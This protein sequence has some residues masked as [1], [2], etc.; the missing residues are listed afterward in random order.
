MSCGPLVQVRSKLLWRLV[1]I[2]MVKRKKCFLWLIDWNSVS[3]PP[4]LLISFIIED[5]LVKVPKNPNKSLFKC[6]QRWRGCP[7][8]RFTCHP[9]HQALQTSMFGT[10]KPR[11][12]WH[13]A[14]L[15]CL[16]TLGQRIAWT[17]ERGCLGMLGF[18]WLGLGAFL[19]FFGRFGSAI[20]AHKLCAQQMRSEASLNYY[21]FE[22]GMDVY[23]TLLACY[24]VIHIFSI[25]ILISNGSTYVYP[26]MHMY[27][28]VDC[29]SIIYICI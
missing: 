20:R 3:S 7:C 6:H 16:P 22:I 15:Q 17:L 23:D 25:P 27:T 5:Y 9:C 11:Y 19:M 1:K 18:L 29:Q 28:F 24:L 21:G 8:W 13:G 2:S 4:R 26:Y 12:G 14:R 10:V